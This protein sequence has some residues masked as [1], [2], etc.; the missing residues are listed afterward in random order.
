ML[1]LCLLIWTLSAFTFWPG[2]SHMDRFQPVH[3]KNQ[4]AE[5]EATKRLS[6][7]PD[8]I[9]ALRQRASALLS[10]GRPAEARRDLER[11]VSLRPDS[12]DL[13]A[14]L[15]YALWL[16]GD[17]KTAKERA[18]KAIELN[19]EHASAHFYLGRLLLITEDDP[20]TAIQH[21]ETAIENNPAE[22]AIRFDLFEAYRASGDQVRA[23]AQ[24]QIL[25]SAYPPKDPQIVYA[26]GL[27]AADL[28]NLDLAIDRFR[29]AATLDPALRGVRKDFGMA[30]IQKERWGDAAT[31]FGELARQQPSSSEAAYFQALSLFNNRQIEEA[32]R[33]VER[34]LRDDS[35]FVPGHTLKGIILASRGEHQNAAASFAEATRLSPKNFEAQFYRGRQAFTLRNLEEA[36]AALTTAVQLQ[37]GHPEA[38][39][40]LST[41]LESLG[42]FEDAEEEYRK[43][44]KLFPDSPEAYTGLGVLLTKQDRLEEAVPYLEKAVELNPDQF[45]AHL[46]LGRILV[47]THHFEKAVSLLRRA[48]E[49]NPDSSAAHFQLATAL[50]RLGHSMEAERE[51]EIVR[52]LNERQRSS[53]MEPPLENKPR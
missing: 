31:V 26:E 20:I 33:V 41:T 9:D 19:P 32:W 53:G 11:A 4:Q 22:M 2:Q 52:R 43:M 46:T 34:L 45:E 39:F 37:P 16:T 14:D 50:Q 28:G 49:L 24:L 21:L 36:L 48:V 30:L 47:R 7:D 27:V 8:D 1:R 15:A 35:H 23:A 12:A 13:I 44:I 42:R 17:L 6:S 51:F 5:A 29:E 38:R 3:L 40:F 25:Q 10:L 18:A